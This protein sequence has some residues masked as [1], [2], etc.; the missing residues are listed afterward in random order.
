MLETCF[1]A[2]DLRALSNLRASHFLPAFCHAKF[3]LQH[4]SRFTSVIK[5]YF[6]EPLHVCVLDAK[7]HLADV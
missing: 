7:L 4:K 1:N 6:F 5:S 3:V 2:C